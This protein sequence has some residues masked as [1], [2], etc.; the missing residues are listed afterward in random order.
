[1]SRLDQP[2]L[3]QHN[4]KWMFE[5]VF[6]YGE[7]DPADPKPDGAGDWLS[8]NDPF[9]SFRA[10]FEVRTYRLCQRILQ[11][12]H[13]PGEQ[14]VGADCLVRSLDLAYKS[15]RG[16]PDDVRRG[17]PIASC[18]ASITHTGYRRNPAPA[19][20]YVAASLP[21]L[22][23]EYSEPIVDD[24]VREV[25][26]ASL[27]NLPGGIDGSTYR[28]VDL[29]GEGLSGILTEQADEW[30]YKPSLGEGRF[31]PV[32]TLAARPSSALVGEGRRELVDLAGDGQ[33]D[34]VE[35]GGSTTGFFERTT[36]CD[37]R[38]FTTFDS[39]PNLDWQDSNLRLVDLTGDGLA[40]VLLTRGDALVSHV[41]LGEDGFGA[42]ERLPVPT[43]EEA[44]PRLLFA[45]GTQSAY[46]ADMS[47]DGLSDLVRI[48]QGS[49]AVWPNLG[50]GTVRREDRDG[51]CAALR[52]RG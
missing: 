31:G 23:F 13:F 40:D 35:L 5:V 43:D 21:P 28:W 8:R 11:F 17:N 32:E 15:S 52:A 38:P 6:D 48:R 20:G 29:D 12:H 36:D 10:G 1:M 24:R 44:G 9:S 16:V 42:E 51:R 18:I 50:H 47:G 22:E 41:S 30:F 7:H 2:D 33:L 34:L 3:A 14:D 27:E 4:M 45:D 46:L 19:N 37:W 39:L 49:V 25:D 26:G